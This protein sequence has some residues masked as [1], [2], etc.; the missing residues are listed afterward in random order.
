M[1]RVKNS[2][3]SHNRDLGHPAVEYQS[4]LQDENSSLRNSPCHVRN[5]KNGACWLVKLSDDLYLCVHN[6]DA[7]KPETRYLR[8]PGS[9]DNHTQDTGRDD[10]L[11]RSILQLA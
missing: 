10:H 11:D 8:R 3:V 5:L 1:I 4:A 9:S 2:E 7:D 6:Q